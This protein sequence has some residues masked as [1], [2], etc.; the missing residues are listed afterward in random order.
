MIKELAKKYVKELRNNNS[1]YVLPSLAFTMVS[2]ISAAFW[3]SAP[4]V[5]KVI[6]TFIVVVMSF[7]LFLY[8]GRDE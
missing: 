6:T 5:L 4:V 2:L 3:D 8:T 7:I 1:K